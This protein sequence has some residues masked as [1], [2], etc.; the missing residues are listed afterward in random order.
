MARKNAPVFM[1]ID[2]TGCNWDDPGDMRIAKEMAN[3][4]FTAATLKHP[5]DNRLQ[6]Y[7]LHSHC[8]VFNDRAN[9]IVAALN[10]LCTHRSVFSDSVNQIV[11]GPTR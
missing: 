3:K 11:T 10:V 1:W 2:G 6:A 5:Y 4:G 8:K 7:P 9:H